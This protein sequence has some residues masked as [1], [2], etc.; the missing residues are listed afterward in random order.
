MAKIV[1]DPEVNKDLWKNRDISSFLNEE[2]RDYSLYC[3]MERA[4]PSLIDGF[5]ITQRK[6]LHS[7]FKGA[8]KNGQ[9]VKLLNLTGD[10][11]K[12]TLYAHGDG[13]LNG[14]IVGLGQS[15]ADNLNP[16]YIEGQCGTLRDQSSVSAPRYLYVKLNKYADLYKVDSDLLEYINEEGQMVEPKHYLPIIPTVLCRQGIGLAPGYR[17]STMSYNPIDIIDSCTNIIKGGKAKT[18]RPYIRGIKQKNWKYVSNGSNTGSWVNKGEWSYNLK[19]DCME[20]TDLPYDLG[21]DDFEKLLNKYVDNG[22][23]KDWRN[24]SEGNSIKYDLYFETGKLKGYIKENDTFLPN[25]FKLIKTVPDDQL[26]VLDENNKVRH[27]VTTTDL[28]EYFTSYRLN[29][30]NKRKVKMVSVLEQKLASNT[31]MCRFIDLIIKGKL[32]INNRPKADIKA[33]MVVYNI[34]ETLIGTP[35]S[36]LTKE[37]YE[38]LLKENEDIKKELEYIKNTTIEDMY[39]TDLKNLRKNLLVDFPIEKD[40]LDNVDKPIVIGESKKSKEDKEIEKIKKQKDK[41]KKAKE[42]EKLIK[43]KE[44]LKKDKERAK[45]AKE[46]EIALKEK[47]KENKKKTKEQIEKIKANIEKLKK[48][49]EKARLLKDKDKIASIKESIIANK[50]KIESLKTIKN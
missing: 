20:I 24:Y 32:K 10:T 13:S 15:F 40:V 42:K 28:I 45:K 34:P 27:F 30:Y 29:I 37:E 7:A 16:L 26:Y 47:E 44:K 1:A 23:L 9:L 31:D 11:L 8:C 2:Y 46:K 14:G 41:E 12:E 3:A 6:I 5:K 35:I 17:F 22:F 36:K 43:E 18:V 38:A 39:L 21:F 50:Q 25:K 4:C 33:D 49:L 48:Q 19:Y